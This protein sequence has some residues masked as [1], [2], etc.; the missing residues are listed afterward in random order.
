LYRRGV[1][2][3]RAERF[4]SACQEFGASYKL[5]PHPGVLYTLATC[6]ARLGRVATAAAHYEDFLRLVATLPPEQQAI[7]AER[8]QAAAAQLSTLAPQIPYVTVSLPEG[9]P[10]G[11]V[12]R[13]DGAPLDPTALGRRLPV[14][15]GDHIVTLEVPGAPLQEQPVA[16]GRGENK[17]LTLRLPPTPPPALRIPVKERPTAPA[18][19][20]NAPSSHGGSSGLWWSATVV[21]G[22][23]AAAGT[24]TGILAFMDKNIVGDECKGLAC[25]QRGKSAADRGKVEALTS[26]ISFGVAGVGLVGMAIGYL[27]QRPHSPR[28]SVTSEI[29]SIG[30]GPNGFCVS[31]RF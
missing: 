19:P 8:K 12:V 14:D 16:L 25:T 21:F 13:R 29:P 1:S 22:I 2:D 20:V 3:F 24:T 9:L 26:T 27:L 10:P 28:A 31:G 23:G 7:Q 18:P 4:D 15:P 17:T 6:E 30:L 11:A 5:D